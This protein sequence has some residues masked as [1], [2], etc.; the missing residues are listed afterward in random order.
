VNARNGSLMRIGPVA[1]PHLGDS[2][3]IADAAAAISAPTQADP[4][5]TDAC[6]LWSVAVGEAVETGELPGLR[7]GLDHLAADRRDQWKKISDDAETQPPGVFTP[8]DFSSRPSRQHGQRSPKPRY[9]KTYRPDTTQPLLKRRAHH[10][11]CTPAFRPRRD[12]A[13]PAVGSHSGAAVSVEPGGGCRWASG[14]IP[15]SR[16]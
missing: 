6:V 10:P 13:T 3:H 2:D 15:P 8:N 14:I 7:T 4:F 1:V 16:I 11:D 5:A 12:S 9:P